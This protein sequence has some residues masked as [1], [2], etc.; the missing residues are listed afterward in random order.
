MKKADNKII[1][2]LATMHKDQQKFF[3]DQ[4]EFNDKVDGRL[5]HIDERQDLFNMRLDEFHTIQAQ[6]QI[7]NDLRF[8]EIYGLLDKQGSQ[9]KN[10]EKKISGG[11]EEEEKMGVGNN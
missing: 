6:N 4:R 2:T 3:S 9:I 1:Q 10:I 8:Q 11:I 7:Q 5:D